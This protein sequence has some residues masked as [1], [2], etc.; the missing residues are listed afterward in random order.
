MQFFTVVSIKVGQQLEFSGDKWAE[1][2]DRFVRGIESEDPAVCS[3]PRLILCGTGSQILGLRYE[4]KL[5]GFYAYASG[6]DHL[7]PAEE[8]SLLH[9]YSGHDARAIM[10]AFH[11]LLLLRSRGISLAMTDFPN[12][13][14]LA[15]LQGVGL[16]LR[17]GHQNLPDNL[18][19]YGARVNGLQRKTAPGNVVY[20]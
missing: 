3:W 20:A 16:L 10:H 2:L 15:I 18:S 6:S 5:D 1:A 9:E 17:A 7:Q 19:A 11:Q 12:D 13:A 8:G 14:R 4:Q